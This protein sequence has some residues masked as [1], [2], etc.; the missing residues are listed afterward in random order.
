MHFDDNFVVF[1]YDPALIPDENGL[2][3]IS[4]FQTVV[5]LLDIQ[6]LDIKRRDPELCYQIMLL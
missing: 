4:D 1:D 6:D 5:L 2:S 3:Q